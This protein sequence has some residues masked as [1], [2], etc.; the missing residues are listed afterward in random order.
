MFLATMFT[1]SSFTFLLV[2]ILLQVSDISAFP[3]NATVLHPGL[4][5][6]V[7]TISTDATPAAPHFF[8][9]GDAYDETIGPPAVSTI[10]VSYLLFSSESTIHTILQGFNVL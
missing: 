8:V 10:K 1:I 2:S 7:H 3:T 6:S 9:Y 5:H 4:G